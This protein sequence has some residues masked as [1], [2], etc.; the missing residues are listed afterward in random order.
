MSRQNLQTLCQPNLFKETDLKQAA[1][2]LVST[3]AVVLDLI[4][5]AE[6]ATVSKH[7]FS[8]MTSDLPEYQCRKPSDRI[9]FNPAGKLGGSSSHHIIVRTLRARVLEL[10]KALLKRLVL[11]LD[12]SKIKREVLQ[13]PAISCIPDA[14]MVRLS[15]DK[16]GS[17]RDSW[18]EDHSSTDW[19]FG[20]WLNLDDPDEIRPQLFVFGKGSHL[21]AG[22]V[23]KDRCA[24]FKKLSGQEV[25]LL[26]QTT[27][28]IMP[29]QLLVFFE[30][31]A[32]TV[33]NNAARR[34][35]TY[36]MRLF[37]ACRLSYQGHS[38]SHEASVQQLM[39]QRRPLPIKGGNPV[40]LIPR[41]GFM[42]NS[43]A[44]MDRAY[45]FVRNNVASSLQGVFLKNLDAELP[46][47]DLDDSKFPPY[48]D[49]EL[50]LYAL[51]PLN[52]SRKRWRSGCLK[53]NV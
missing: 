43:R 16:I 30:N 14:A 2:E 44:T 5:S 4:P 26:D 13:N 1:Q 35:T 20:G 48:T 11:L 22:I 41:L 46:E 39:R 17:E 6:L 51:T 53:E 36:M 40:P 50:S 28:T 9:T 47:L 7:F 49:A 45:D 25:A 42:R 32:H 37:T 12:D 52:V 34:S 21:K 31:V 19:V 10:H 8:A 33:C 24:G 27:K 15:K 18:H 23:Q 38:S 29:G 3:G